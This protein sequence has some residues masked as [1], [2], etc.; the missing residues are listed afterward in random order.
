[1]D[2]WRT[3]ALS[4]WRLNAE[5]ETD[6]TALRILACAAR[7][8]PG[9]PMPGELLTLSLDPFGEPGTA[10]PWPVTRA[11]DALERLTE[12]GLLGEEGDGA[13][14]MHR[15]VAAFALAEISDDE[16]QAAVEAACSRAAL[17]AFSEGHPGRQEALLPHVRLLAD[18][19]MA[20]VD[21]PAA[22]LCTAAGVG[23]GQLGA[24]D[25]ALPYAQRAVD[26][27]ADLHGPND[28]LTLQR[29]SNVGMLLK[30]KRDWDVARA[31]YEEVLE[32]QVTHLE[33]ED[34]DVAATINNMGV[35]LRRE[36]LYH[37][38]LSLYRRALRIR[39]RVWER[40][41]PDDP[42]RRGN[43]YKVAESHSNMGALMMDLGRPRQAGPH[44]D[45][46]LGIMEGEFGENHERNAGTLVMRGAALRA[47]GHY[48][49]AVKS[50]RSALDIYGDVTRSAPPAVARALANLGSIFAEWAEE[51]GTLSVEQRA[52]LREI[53]GG[54]LQAALTG[55]EHGYG[56][57]HLMTGGLNRA[58]GE[59]RGAQG[60]AEDA[61]RHREQADTCRRLNLRG[62]DAEA[63]VAINEAGGALVPS[64]LYD[65]AQAY[66]ER[67]LAIREGV[68]KERNFATST[69]L[70]KLGIL[71]QLRGRDSRARQYLERALAARSHVCG[72]D[73]PAT[74]VVR[75]N[76]RLLES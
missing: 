52:Q 72:V 49:H 42:D 63:A 29:R 67:A 15:L 51:D 9:E 47:L 21:D 4:Y 12:V 36:D 17:E 53:A 71:F 10:P 60:A 45:S 1:M 23:L 27:T 30:N 2:V 22:N 69:S 41:G 13:F 56:E 55:S 37:E 43:A 20:R 31:V 26:I 5:D 68:L 16:A 58:L 65:E 74:E 38:M 66:L 7:L 73:H 3:F 28:R 8:A 57:D 24:Y 61:R 14:G 50:V 39:E 62:K 11:R 25:E 34:I 59:V 40:T 32:A 33:R 70:F 75:D 18:A 64:G 54:S 6:G 76:L 44:F 46:A 35:L 48:P 19:A